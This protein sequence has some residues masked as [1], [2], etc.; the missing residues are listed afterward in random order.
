MC[1]SSVVMSA[2]VDASSAQ[3]VEEARV[4][5][6]F[7]SNDPYQILFLIG[8][9]EMQKGNYPSA[10]KIFRSL[11]QSARTRRIQLEL[12]RALFLDRQFKEARKLFLEIY[13]DPE[14]PLS[15][16]ENIKLYLDEADAALGQLKFSFA[17]VSD[18]NPAGFTDARK[19][20]IGGQ[21]LYLVPP[22]EN[23]TV[24]GAKY[25]LDA[26]KALTDDASVTAYLNTTFTDYQGGDFDRLDAD[27]GFVFAPRGLPKFRAKIGMEQALFGGSHLYEYP[28][29]T[30]IFIPKPFNQF[31]WRYELEYGHL[32]VS[33]VNNLEADKLTQVLN[34]K[35]RFA[36]DN[37][38]A[39]NV[40]LEAAE[41]EEDP[42]S[43]VGGGLGGE[44]SVPINDHWG[45]KFLG[46]FSLREFDGVDPLFGSA[47]KDDSYT[48]GL[49]FF[50]RLIKLFGREP[51]V[52][53]RYERRNSNLE[54]FEFDRVKLVFRLT[55][56]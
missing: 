40:F 22:D 5:L 25:G 7:Q 39:S 14:V 35:R 13:E 53:I 43:Y 18:S 1:L 42:Y 21:T 45:V 24:I 11:F 30:L 23:E 52:G 6:A 16:R 19:I 9:G 10:V 37:R 31:R 34:A 41:T 50:S 2:A 51:E 38:L 46:S 26:T 55:E 3:S 56:R 4:D 29:A 33:H 20:T 27:G 48:V 54:F 17:I 15:V 44:L 47:R 32:N 12:A 8:V 28:Y 49:S 36:R